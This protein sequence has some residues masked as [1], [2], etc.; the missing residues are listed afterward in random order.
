MLKLMCC[1][2]DVCMVNCG[3]MLTTEAVCYMYKAEAG[4]VGRYR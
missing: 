2:V 4:A 1:Y 3:A